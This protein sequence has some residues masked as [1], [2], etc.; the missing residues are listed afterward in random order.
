MSRRHARSGSPYEPRIGFSR[1][2]RVDLPGGASLVEVSGTGPVWPDGSCDPDPRA[3]AD[4][5]WEIALAALDELGA[6]ADDVVRTRMYVTDRA[7]QDPVGE[8][9]AA[10]VGHAMPAATMVVVSGLV[11]PRW[12]VEL[13]VEAVVTDEE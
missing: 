2:V 6:S 9:H 5:C 11:D 13:E 4:R 1:A 7:V 12:V 3:Q 8:S 10:H